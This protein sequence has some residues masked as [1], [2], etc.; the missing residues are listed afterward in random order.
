MNDRVSSWKLEK[1]PTK[2]FAV[3]YEKENY[4]GVAI[5][6]DYYNKYLPGFNDKISSVKISPGYYVKFW[7]N[8]KYG[9]EYFRVKQDTPSFKPFDWANRIS[10]LKIYEMPKEYALFYFE[11]NFGGYPVMVKRDQPKM[12]LI[13]DKIRSI[14]I[15]G[16]FDKFIRVYEHSKFNGKYKDFFEDTG[17]L[18]S[19]DKKVTSFS[20]TT[21][22][23]RENNP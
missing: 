14:K 22:P 18:G 9:G 16:K 7:R 17:S 1:F 19:L 6:A 4:G 21:D 20:F 5:L 12:G 8:S 11:K 23:K 10:S 2:K 15:V 13:S 3:L